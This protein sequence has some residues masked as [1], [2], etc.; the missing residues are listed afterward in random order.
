MYK[1]KIVS[2]IEGSASAALMEKVTEMKKAEIDVIGLAGGEPD[3]DTPDKIRFRGI[4]ALCEGK[5]HY[6]IGRGIPE[7]RQ[8]ICEKF[9]ED[10]NI[11]SDPEQ[12]IVTPGGKFA[13]Y[14]AVRSVI[15]PGDE[16]LILDP[17]WVSYAPMIKAANGV[18]VSVNLTFAD[19][20]M[21]TEEKLAEAYSRKTKLLIVNTPNNPTG[22]VL[23]EDEAQAIIS[24]V[25]KYD[26]L[27]FSDEIYEKIIFDNR[28]HISLGSYPEIADKVITMN[29]LSKCV[30]M[31]GWRLGYLTAP[32]ELI[33][34][35]SK[36]YAHTISCVSPF[37]QEAAIV[38]LDC[39]KEME[40][41][42]LAYE[43]RRNLFINGLNSIPNVTAKMPEGAFYAWVK[44]EK[45]K[46]NSFQLA[47][48][49]LKEAKVAGVP[50]DAYGKG[51]DQCIRFSF[52]SDL[53]SL[54]EAVERIRK[55]V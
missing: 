55:V 20:Y 16:V 51:G 7:L 19:N 6:A 36:L 45:E 50:G 53:N 14:L 15:N 44:F 39:K 48:Y 11:I 25:K 23:T 9:K 47:D 13:A 46:M 26:V 24:F 38:A 12:I 35:M 41:M 49:L 34:T 30:A 21:I 1:N 10:N 5:T 2:S 31:T 43:K 4:Q 28:S 27:V 54:L 42:R 52:A 8:K 32:K 37:I 17:S 22:R 40:E 18:P 33:T 29:G 3:F